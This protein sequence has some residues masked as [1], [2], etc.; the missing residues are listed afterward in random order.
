MVTRIKHNFSSASYMQME[1]PDDFLDGSQEL[2]AK[3]A[4]GSLP[5]YVKA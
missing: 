4:Y 1:P 3:F 5:F 2:S